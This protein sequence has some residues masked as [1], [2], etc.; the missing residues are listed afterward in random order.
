MAPSG[1]RRK[2]F[3]IQID[4]DLGFRPSLAL[5]SILAVFQIERFGFGKQA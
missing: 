5:R 1:R 3:D 2:G 4:R